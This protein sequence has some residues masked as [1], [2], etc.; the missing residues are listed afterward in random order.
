MRRTAQNA[1]AGRRRTAQDGSGCRLGRHN[2][3]PLARAAACVR[4]KQDAPRLRPT[5]G[6]CGFARLRGVFRPAGRSKAGPGRRLAPAAR[7]SRWIW[8]GRS[9]AVPP[10]RAR[11]KAPE[12]LLPKCDQSLI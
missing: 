4:I 1:R 10:E 7:L 9:D 8:T 5:R 3:R 12:E 11:P 2:T 6:K